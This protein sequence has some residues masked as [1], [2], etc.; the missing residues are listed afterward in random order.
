DFSLAVM[1]VPPDALGGPARLRLSIDRARAGLE[2]AWSRD[3][4]S[5]LVIE[6]AIV[7]AAARAIED[8]S[9]PSAGSAPGSGRVWIDPPGPE[10][11]R[12]TS[13]SVGASRVELS[14]AFDL[15]AADRRVRG[16]QAEAIL[17]EHLPR[18]GMA[19]LLFP[20]RRVNEEKKHVE[21][22]ARR[23]AA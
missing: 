5:R 20:L 16:Q 14:L 21:E 9:G 10:L 7:R 18:V 6:D 15:P 8:L 17:F 1:S 22:A 3:E 2:G 19:A 12:R 4:I 11:A 23:G 13:A